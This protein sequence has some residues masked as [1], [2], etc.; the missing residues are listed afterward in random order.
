MNYWIIGG[1]VVKFFFAL[2]RCKSCGK[3]DPD[4]WQIQNQVCTIGCFGSLVQTPG[5]SQIWFRHI[6]SCFWDSF[7]F[8]DTVC[9]IVAIKSL[10]WWPKMERKSL[11]QEYCSARFKIQFLT[12]GYQAGQTLSSRSNHVKTY[13][14]KAGSCRFSVTSFTTPFYPWNLKAY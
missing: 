2:A 12:H 5:T 11:F 3:T 10:F 1:W 6:L 4:Q 8:Q 14:Q 13:F 7:F 9:H